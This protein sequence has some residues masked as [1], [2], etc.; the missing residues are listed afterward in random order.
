MKKC[1]ECGKEN[2]DNLKYCR[3]NRDGFKEK[4]VEDAIKNF[5]SINFYLN[6]ELFV[7]GTEMGDGSSC[8]NI[9]GYESI[10]YEKPCYF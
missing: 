7:Q 6:G 3:W 1:N 2:A 8:F 10:N 4:D 9:F 5:E